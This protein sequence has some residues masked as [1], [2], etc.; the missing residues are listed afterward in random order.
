MFSRAYVIQF[1]W[2]DGDFGRRGR[3][4]LKSSRDKRV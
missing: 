2:R 3:K 1:V 4:L